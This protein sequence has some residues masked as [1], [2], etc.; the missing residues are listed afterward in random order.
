MD[1]TCKITKKE[2]TSSSERLHT[3]MSVEDRILFLADLIAQ[4][5][6]DEQTSGNH[7]LKRIDRLG[8]GTT[9]ATN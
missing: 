1:R 5:I 8:D 2:K 4:K 7:L 9:N 3:N 6:K